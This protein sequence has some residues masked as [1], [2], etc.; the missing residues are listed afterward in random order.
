MP[1]PVSLSLAARDLDILPGE[2]DLV[3]GGGILS[4]FDS[5][6]GSGR[7]AAHLGFSTHRARRRV[8]TAGTDVEQPRFSPDRPRR[9][10][11]CRGARDY[12]SRCLSDRCSLIHVWLTAPSSN[13]VSPR[14]RRAR[15][16][17]SPTAA[18]P[19]SNAMM[20][21]PVTGP[22]LLDRQRHEPRDLRPL[23]NHPRASAC[24]R[25]IWLV[26]VNGSHTSAPID[27]LL[28]ESSLTR[29][30]PTDRILACRRD[31]TL[32]GRGR[33]SDSRSHSRGRPQLPCP[34]GLRARRPSPMMDV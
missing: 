14:E 24:A 2:L 32:V 15:V 1:V 10:A 11:D 25:S 21:P 28:H 27:A 33:S 8:S 31:T 29:T 4:A 34:A 20:I 9:F 12:R 30:T 19:T 22:S 18:I 3:A 23:Q 16:T 26:R 17:T 5:R 13:S 6:P 7:F